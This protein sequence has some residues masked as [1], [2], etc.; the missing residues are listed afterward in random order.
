VSERLTV[1]VEEEYH[2]VDAD[3]R[4]L[5]N[6]ADGILAAVPDL[7]DNVFESEIKQTM[8]EAATAVCATLADIR[9]NITLLREGLVRAAS[10]RNRLIVAAGSAPIG[11]W[12]DSALTPDERYAGIVDLH[13]QV[14]WEQ[15]VCGC[16]VHIGFA[17]RE[18]A[19]QVLNRV[20][21]WL[22]PLLALSASSPYWLDHDSGYASYRTTVWWRW[23]TA[24]V[25]SSFESTDDYDA[26]VQTL[27]DTGTVVDDGQIY[28]DVRLSA[29]QETLEFRV[30]DTCTTV[31]EAVLHAALCRA[32]AT[33]ARDAA[34]CDEPLPPVRAE[35]L[36][37]AKWRAAR[38]GVGDLLLD[39]SHG[40]SVPAAVLVQRLLDHL[41]PV[42]DDL[43]EWDEVNELADQVL[44]R[45]SSADRQR[46]AYER[47]G[48]LPAVVDHLAAETAPA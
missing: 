17:D 41:R 4:R 3:T 33:T 44:R 48:G 35:L 5:A 42:L 14:V 27:V 15:I 38:F 6:D 36:R 30:A 9:R 31:D 28:W 7:G 39:P 26:L 20:R 24:H 11:H 13:Q 45:G 10:E 43:G 22:S 47:G 32:L 23:P 2:V 25:P 46:A 16:H 8:V 37:A 29:K 1:G 34:L 12:R 18:L 19:L 21:P 40:E